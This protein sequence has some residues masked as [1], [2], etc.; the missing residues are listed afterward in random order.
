MNENV[1]SFQKNFAADVKRLVALDRQLRYFES[2]LRAE[3]T[4]VTGR[5]MFDFTPHATALQQKQSLDELE[6][7]FD[8]VESEL[9]QLAANEA[10]L[11]AEHHRCVEWKYVLQRAGL[12]VEQVKQ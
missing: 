7:K 5:A 2:Q 10:K 6:A 8:E 3:R 9:R 1:S 12:L 4:A 11:D